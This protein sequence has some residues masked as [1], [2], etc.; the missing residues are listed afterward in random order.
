MGYCFDELM[1]RFIHF[2]SDIVDRTFGFLL[3][4]CGQE[5]AW[6]IY[7]ILLMLSVLYRFANNR[8]FVGDPITLRPGAPTGNNVSKRSDTHYITL[9]SESIS[10]RSHNLVRLI[11]LERIALNS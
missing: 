9:Q 3:P 6:L 7:V 4:W 1:F 5:K 2:L 10:S 11:S 8:G